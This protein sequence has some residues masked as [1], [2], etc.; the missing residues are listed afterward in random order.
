MSPS[1]NAPECQE[2]R[3]EHGFDERQIAA[4]MADHVA[5]FRGPIVARQ[6]S[7]GQSNPTFLIE[8]PSGRY[9]MRRKPP[10]PL[11]PG[12][13][14]IEREVRVMRG[15]EQTGFEVPHV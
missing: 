6:F 15:L 1:A 4:W 3:D 7:G 12:A 10:G 11:L 9:V 5:G 2:V 13:H 14:A 8:C